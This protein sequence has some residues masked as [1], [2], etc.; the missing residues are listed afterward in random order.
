MKPRTYA[1]IILAFLLTTAATNTYAAISDNNKI[2]V[3]ERIATMTKGEKMARLGEIKNRVNEIKEMDKSGL[4]KP[5]RKDL[6]KELRD[7]RREAR[8]I[9]GGV[10]L[11]AGAIII[12][13]LLLI[14]IL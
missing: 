13:I 3:K 8:V 14:L 1:A 6:K 4:T 5:E 10:Y 9:S 7:M 11:S 12:I 2:P